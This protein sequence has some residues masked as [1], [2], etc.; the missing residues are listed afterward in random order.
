M[1]E[2]GVY[3]VDSPAEIGSK[4]AEVLGLKAN[5]KISLF[6]A[7]NANFFLQLFVGK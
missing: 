1:A 3:V 4:M 7:I 6:F 2:C 5:W